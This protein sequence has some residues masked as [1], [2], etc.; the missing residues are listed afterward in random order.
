M[1]DLTEIPETALVARLGI[2]RAAVKGHRKRA[3]DE[4]VHWRKAGRVIVYTEA[5]AARLIEV[6]GVPAPQDE[7]KSLTREGESKA[8]ALEELTFVRGGFVNDRV[9]LARREGGEVVT[10]RVRT[11]KNFRPADHRGEPMRFPARFDGG[12]WMIE[13]PLPRWPGKW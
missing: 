5:G 1:T 12:V 11:S 13:R 3:L 6:V 4:G 8:D 9:I 2:S 10:V 7:A